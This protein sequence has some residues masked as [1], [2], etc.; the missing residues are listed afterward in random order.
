M[1]QK[2][3]SSK[4]RRATK[5]SQHSAKGSKKIPL[6]ELQKILMVNGGMGHSRLRQGK[7][8]TGSQNAKRGREKKESTSS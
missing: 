1:A 4:K 3:G 6:T 2:Q 5:T 8:L 7:S